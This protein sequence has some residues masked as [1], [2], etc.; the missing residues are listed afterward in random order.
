[1]SPSHQLLLSM[2][3]RHKTSTGWLFQSQVP[4]QDKTWPS[5]SEQNAASTSKGILLG[6]Y[7]VEME[8]TAKPWSRGWSEAQLCN[9]LKFVLWE[10]KGRKTMPFVNKPCFSN[11]QAE[12][13]MLKQDKVTKPRKMLLKMQHSRRALAQ[14]TTRLWAR[15]QGREKSGE[16]K[17]ICSGSDWTY[18]DWDDSTVCLFLS[19]PYYS[20]L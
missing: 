8:V 9:R 10:R 13:S 18:T 11:M 16:M 1:M 19:V 17:K 15:L 4:S 7:C 3:S 12:I 6:H 2:C 20:L 14:H 5:P